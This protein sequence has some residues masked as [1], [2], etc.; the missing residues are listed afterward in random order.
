MA[1]GLF[2]RREPDHIHIAKVCTNWMSVALTERV[3]ER[4]KNLETV[5]AT[6]LYRPSIVTRTGCRDNQQ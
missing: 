3:L 6:T 4:V 5:R 2:D 1:E